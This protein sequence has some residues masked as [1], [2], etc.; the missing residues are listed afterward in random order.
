M[1]RREFIA[2]VGGAIASSSIWALTARAQ[3]D[4]MRRIGVL[5]GFS[6]HDPEAQARLSALTRGLSELGWIDG[7]NLRID[8][9]WAGD[10][11]ERMRT[12]AKEL[13]DLRP[14]V[15]LSGTTPLTAA[16]QQ[17]TRTIP[18]VFTGISDPVGDGFVAGLAHPGGNITGF[19][20]LEAGMGGKWLQLLTEIA[21][22]VKRVAIIFNPETAPGGGSYYLTPFES[23]TRTLKIEP[24]VALV[25]SE[26]EIEMIMTT[27]GRY[28]G[29]G[30][31]VVPDAFT[32]I[33]RVPIILLAARN[34]VPAVYWRSDFARNGG[35]YQIPA[36]LTP[37]TIH[38]SS[39]L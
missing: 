25:H 19:I 7:H 27:L 9:R 1:K 6:E 30:L 36:I 29:G 22:E 24:I 32:F 5:L 13:V 18:I 8:V 11:V 23:A 39:W 10:S 35:L 14:E 4:R 28:P 31:V 20:N 17:E 2:G 15:V 12:F 33:H 34:N 26:A 16:L 37:S 21:P 3:G 38:E